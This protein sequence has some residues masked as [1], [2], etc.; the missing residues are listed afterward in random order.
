M[1]TQPGAMVEEEENK[2]RLALYRDSTLI[3]YVNNLV[4]PMS[5]QGSFSLDCWDAPAAGSHTYYLKALNDQEGAG[6]TCAG[7]SLFV[8]EL[9][10]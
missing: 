2:M 9:K 5:A 1:A 10:K 4:V 3:A 7:R 8:I 6:L